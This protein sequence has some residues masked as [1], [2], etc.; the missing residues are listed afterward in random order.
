MSPAYPYANAEYSDTTYFPVSGVN[1][2][3]F[4]PGATFNSSQNAGR[5]SGGSRG[6]VLRGADFGSYLST[7]LFGTNLA[8]GPTESHWTIGFRCA[9]LP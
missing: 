2:L 1:R 8:Y 4:A 6:A 7:G 5:L 9:F 3:N